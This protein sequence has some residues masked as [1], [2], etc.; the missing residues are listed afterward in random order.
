MV[1]PDHAIS[2]MFA[3]HTLSAVTLASD[4]VT[5]SGWGRDATS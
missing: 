2:G 5:A 4:F 3:S 1:Q